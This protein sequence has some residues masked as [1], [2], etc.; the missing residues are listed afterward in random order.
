ML[1]RGRL[2]LRRS[3]EVLGG[4]EWDDGM[5]RE[6]LMGLSLGRP[7]KLMVCSFEA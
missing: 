5:A 4:I 1:W 7:C 3:S 6:D 2:G